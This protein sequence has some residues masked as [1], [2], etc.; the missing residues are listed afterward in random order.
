MGSERLSHAF[1][2]LDPTYK[3]NS[4]DE[5]N[6][7]EPQESLKHSSGTQPVSVSNGP[8]HSSSSFKVKHKPKTNPKYRKLIKLYNRQLTHITTTLDAIETFSQSEN[9][10]ENKILSSNKNR[11]NELKATLDNLHQNPEQQDH[12]HFEPLKADIDQ[13][14]DDLK[15]YKMN[16]G[17]PNTSNTIDHLVG[18]PIDESDS[19]NDDKEE[20]TLIYF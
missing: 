8:S 15:S 5:S 1:T 2:N 9:H 18:L 12:L 13:L 6:T 7:K 19:E 4:F 10:Q 3:P 17:I 11:V 14:I 20:K 16:N